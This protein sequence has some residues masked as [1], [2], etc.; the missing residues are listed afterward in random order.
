MTL[1][2]ANIIIIESTISFFC[3]YLLSFHYYTMPSSSSNEGTDL[4]HRFLRAEKELLSAITDRPE[5]VESFQS[6]WDTL[7]VELQEGVDANALNAET[8]G[9]A[10]TVA[11]RV[12]IIAN[13]FMELEISAR[14]VFLDYFPETLSITDSTAENSLDPLPKSAVYGNAELKVPSGSRG[15]SRLTQDTVDDVNG[16]PIYIDK[17]YHWLLRHLHNPYPSARV[18]SKIANEAGVLVKTVGDWF[19]RTRSRIG[20]TSVVAEHFNGQ[21][22]VAVDWAYCVYAEQDA[23]THVPCRYKE[24]F[25]AIKDRAEHLYDGKWKESDLANS[26]DPSARTVKRQ[27]PSLSSSSKKRA[28]EMAEDIISNAVP[29]DDRCTKRTRLV[30]DLCLL[31]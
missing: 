6:S 26:F 1:P 14:S 9:V 24:A 7:R 16:M 20:W 22:A 29:D 13:S 18:K 8:I 15:I 25:D 28:R 3:Y 21:R 10:N 2:Q 31:K 5:A 17:A 27:Q 11:K 19:T 30:C 12:E 4:Q 23:N